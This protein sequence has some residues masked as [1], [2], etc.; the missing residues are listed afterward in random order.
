MIDINE[1]RKLDVR[2]QEIKKELYKK[3]YEQ[4]ERRIR[5]Q[6][7]LGREKFVI[8]QVPAFVVGFPKFDREAAARYLS[9]QLTR[10]GFDVQLAGDITLFVSWL[11]KPKKKKPREEQEP[12]P[13]LPLEF[14]TLMNLRK[15][16]SAY[17][18]A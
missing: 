17:R 1:I 13:E 10:G 16:A 9:R 3:I 18:K 11:P 7:E 8:L 6:V 4:F 5:Q 14:P 15:A 12:P 2:R